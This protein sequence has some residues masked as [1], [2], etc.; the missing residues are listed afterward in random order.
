[1]RVWPHKAPSLTLL[2]TTSQTPVYCFYIFSRLN[3]LNLQIFIVASTIIIATLDEDWWEKGYDILVWMW[4]FFLDHHPAGR[5]SN[6]PVIT[7]WQK[8]PD[9]HLKPPC[10][11][12]RP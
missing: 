12:W 3:Y 1:M 8:Q 4:R 5:S 7:S 6:D 9:Y 11:S 2:L 10:K